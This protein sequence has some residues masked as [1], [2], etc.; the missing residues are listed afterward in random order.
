M[1]FLVQCVIDSVFF[2][3]TVFVFTSVVVSMPLGYI[4]H[5]FLLLLLYLSDF[6]QINPCSFRRIAD[7]RGLWFSKCLLQNVSK[8][9][10]NPSKGSALVILRCLVIVLKYPF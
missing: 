1:P 9:S 2:P 10:Q 6:F 7:C 4:H 3:F 8:E 5:N